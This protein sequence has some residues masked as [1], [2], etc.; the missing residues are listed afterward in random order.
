MMVDIM[1]CTTRLLLLNAIIFFMVI[2]G[3]CSKD[4]PT[5]KMI[6]DMSSVIVE[7]SGEINN[8]I[9]VSQNAMEFMAAMGLVQH[10]INN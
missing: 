10:C 1:K 5:G 3:R 6:T 4:E 8:V 7:M 2:L 9:C